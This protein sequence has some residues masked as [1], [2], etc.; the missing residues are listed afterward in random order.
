MYAFSVYAQQDSL[1]RTVSVNIDGKKL[2]IMGERHDVKELYDIQYATIEYLILQNPK[3]KNFQLLLEYPPVCNYYLDNLLLKDDSL[4]LKKMFQGSFYPQVD[5]L[6]N[7]H[8]AR[9][10]FL[11]KFYYLSKSLAREGK[12]FRF[13]CFDN[14]YTLRSIVFTIL[15]MLKKYSIQDNDFSAQ[16]IFLDSLLQ[17]EDLLGES[18]DFHE[19]FGR[20]F[21]ENREMF[22]TMLTEI[23]FYHLSEIIRHSPSKTLKSVDYNKK[24]DTQE[25][26]NSMFEQINNSYNDTTF[27]F[28]ITGA[29]HI[30]KPYREYETK[31]QS[32]LKTET[33]DKIVSLGKMLETHKKSRFKNKMILCNMISLTRNEKIY[34][35]DHTYKMIRIP[36]KYPIA[37]QKY[38]DYLNSLLTGNITLIDMRKTNIKGA[39]KIMDYMF[40]VKKANSTEL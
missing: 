11:M 15:E 5:T 36:G 29:N 18:S 3:I 40:V 7:G 35:V 6:N 22:K 25:R 33:P 39:H 13:K 2:L 19:H 17:K 4:G 38:T 27:F 26:E 30:L 34:Q 12:T 16:I 1:F 32:L 37:F 23:D 21:T 28:C 20:Y 10:D 14:G 31:L 8:K 9:Y 24:V